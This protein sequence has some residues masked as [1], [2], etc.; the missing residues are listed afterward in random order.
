MH[1]RRLPRSAGRADFPSVVRPG[2]EAMFATC[3]LVLVT[4]AQFNAGT[5]ML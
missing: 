3:P 5:V 2:V 1:S 4:D